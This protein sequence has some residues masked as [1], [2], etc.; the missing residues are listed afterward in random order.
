MV[1]VAI[2][3]CILICLPF[4]SDE[5]T[6]NAS[7][8]LSS[9]DS[10]LQAAFLNVVTAEK[11]GANVSSLFDMLNEA[12]SNFSV[13][14]A[15]FEAGNYSGAANLAASVA[16]SA[17]EVSSKANALTN[18]AEAQF[19]SWWLT[20]LLSVIGSAA[21]VAVL[22][23]VWHKFKRRYLQRFLKSNPRVNS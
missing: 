1:A 12:G 4:G 2:I 13:A 22:F 3:T 16:D 9:A 11:A 19:S 14:K 21:S 10:L 6:Q 8:S 17:L 15:D 20:I 5:S 18:Q 7:T 23:L